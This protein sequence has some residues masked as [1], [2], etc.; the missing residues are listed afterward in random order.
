M[1]FFSSVN[2]TEIRYEIS[3]K[4]TLKKIRKT[5]FEIFYILGGEKKYGGGKRNCL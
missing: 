5:F 2:F 1:K 3:L 4:F